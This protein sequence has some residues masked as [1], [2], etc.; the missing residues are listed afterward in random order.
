M[1]IEYKK[2]VDKKIKIKK[3]NG[4]LAIAKKKGH[5]NTWKCI[6]TFPCIY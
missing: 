5:D 2:N 1:L 4:I 3:S 6:A